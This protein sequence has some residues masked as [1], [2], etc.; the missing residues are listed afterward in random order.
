MRKRLHNNMIVNWKDV[1]QNDLGFEEE[2][3]YLLKFVLNPVSARAV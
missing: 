2:N 1:V 3:V